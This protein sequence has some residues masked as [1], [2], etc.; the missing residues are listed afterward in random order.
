MLSWKLR[1][2]DIKREI[3]TKTLKFKIRDS[4]QSLISLYISVFHPS[5]SQSTLYNYTPT[6][7]PLPLQFLSISG[8]LMAFLLLLMSSPA[9]GKSKFLHTFSYFYDWEKLGMFGD[10]NP[11]LWD[12]G[13]ELFETH[14]PW[15][16]RESRDE[17]DP[18]LKRTWFLKKHLVLFWNFLKI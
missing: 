14:K 4:S 2:T 12:T 1:Y 8:P 17:W 10:P 7:L 5:Q 3:L 11:S 16:S 6:Y 18:Y 15:M 13:T 9:V